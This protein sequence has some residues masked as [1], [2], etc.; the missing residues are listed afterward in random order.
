MDTKMN[1]SMRKPFWKPWGVG[2]YLGRLVLFLVGLLALVFFLSWLLSRQPVEEDYPWSPVEPFEQPG[3]QNSPEEPDT[4]PGSRR[5]TPP[6][7][8]VR[9]TSVVREWRDSIPGVPELP[10]PNDN[11]IPPIDSTRIVTHPED[12]VGQIV[13]GQLL[14]LLNSQ[15]LKKDVV[16][17][18]QQFKRL[19]PDSVYRVG[20]YNPVAGILLLEVPEERMMQVAEELPKRI[21]DID[22]KVVTND[23][24]EESA[25]P[26][27]PGFATPSYDAY[28]RLIQAYEA[29]EVTKGSRD[30]K[31]AIVDSYFDLTHPEIGVRYV[32]P[33]H[34]PSKT[35]NVLPPN[36]RPSSVG[37]VQAYCHGSHVA[38]I[39][40]GAQNNSLGCSGIA[41]E[42]TWIPVSLGSQL[43]S[44]HIVE[45][46]M[47]AIYKGADVINLSVG[48][49]F[50]KDA[51]QWPLSDQ[52]RIS[53][54]TRM[55]GEELWNYV[56]K[57]ASD[58]KCVICTSAGNA[59]VL[60]GMDPKNRAKG[61]INVEAVDANG[62]MA[63]FSNFGRVPESGLDYSTLAAPGVNLWSTTDRRCAPW[64]RAME[65][66]VNAYEGFQEMSGTSMAS[67]VVTGAVALLKSKNKNLTNEQ[68]IKLL[69]MT[70]KQTDTK[71]RI[72]PTVQLRAALDM[73]G[74][75]LLNF[76][77]LMKNHDLLVG[78]WKSTYELDL[79]SQDGKKD[80]NVL[81]CYFVFTS[82]AEGRVEYHRVDRNEI[83]QAPLRVAWGKDKINITQ[84]QEAVSLQGNRIDKDDFVCRPN[85]KRLL[86]TSCQRNGQERFTFL[87]EKVN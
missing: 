9:D 59:S 45:G 87:L 46:L 37:E 40:I 16:S 38:G 83:Y 7:V 85:V 68:V 10:D 15:D 11:Y 57:M 18:A 20:Y 5:D 60:M 74:G 28:F 25:V 17:F 76:D 61:I 53:K 79:V 42:C 55:R 72:G 86:E 3:K 82:T 65:D 2:G 71:H 35:R 36:A 21:T 84:L 63:D 41:P 44:V 47:Y 24:W 6:P 50:P 39:A 73:T 75:D 58:H 51:K 43:S 27:D 23:I 30:V 22:F 34:I 54:E 32:D 70:A 19:Y 81:W 26:S 31:V 64:I 80:E 33:I 48:S 13:A 14:V 12:S 77:D 1:N 49:A 66:E 56:V 29:W 4:L 62:I 52:V 69:T 78:K 67:P 8:A